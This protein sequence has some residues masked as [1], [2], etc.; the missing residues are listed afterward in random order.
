MNIVQQ[1]KQV[2][3]MNSQINQY[4]NTIKYSYNTPTNHTPANTAH[5]TGA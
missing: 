4:K 5:V 3:N 2:R 1:P